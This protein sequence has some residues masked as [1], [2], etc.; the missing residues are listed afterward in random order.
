M[1]LP[2]CITS[3]RISRNIPSRL[4][5]TA[6]A[7]PARRSFTVTSQRWKKRQTCPHLVERIFVDQGPGLEAVPADLVQKT[8]RLRE[9]HA[10]GLVV[11][12]HRIAHGEV[13]L[14]AGEC[15][16]EE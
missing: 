12:V 9:D 4:L 1:T 3:N 6:S 8:R 5:P 11:D 16:V 14:R 13:M 7:P 2:F 15:D 10:R